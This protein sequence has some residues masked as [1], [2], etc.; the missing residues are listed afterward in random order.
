M[1]FT[2]YGG[3]G[4]G[5]VGLT[6]PSRASPSQDRNPVRNPSSFL[7]IAINFLRSGGGAGLIKP[8]QAQH[9]TAS[10]SQDRNLEPI[11]LFVDCDQLFCVV[12]AGRE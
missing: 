8:S 2:K 5:G 4:G 6:K 7:L 3:G 12:A 10:P 1:I 11:L 9:S